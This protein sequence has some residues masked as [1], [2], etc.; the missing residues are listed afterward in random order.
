MDID[1]VV[2]LLKNTELSTL[3][4]EEIEQ[5][6]RLMKAVE[7]LVEF[8]TCEEYQ[9]MKEAEEYDP[10][11][12]FSI[13]QINP[14]EEDEDDEFAPY[15]EMCRKYN[16]QY[17]LVEDDDA[18]Y[19]MALCYQWLRYSESQMLTY[20]TQED[21]RVRPWHYA[22]QGFTAPKT[23]FPS[24]MI[25]P[26][27]W[28]CRCFL[29]AENGDAYAKQNIRDVKASAIPAKPKQLNDVFSESICTGGRIFGPSHPY[30][31]VDEADK[32]MLIRISDNIKAKYYGK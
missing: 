26:I 8:A 1:E 22:L 13:V 14:E 4:Q 11:F 18:E 21:D 24:W 12:D 2:Q 3:T 15:W 28:G 27:E 5:R 23:D 32:S 19:A 30:F 10:E 25:P 20:M 29:I 7:N 6:D 9:L 17:L 31:S 16:S